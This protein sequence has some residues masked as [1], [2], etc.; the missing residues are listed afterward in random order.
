MGYNIRIVST[1]PPRK[2]GIATFSRNLATAL[3]RLTGE[4]GNVDVAAIDDGNGPYHYPVDLLI[5]QKDSD[6]WIRN[7]AIII[8]RAK[9]MRDPSFIFLQHE[10]GLDGEGNGDNFQTIAGM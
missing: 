4:R 7:A 10:Y 5:D 3:G 6:S 8:A 9:E 2:C 1:Y